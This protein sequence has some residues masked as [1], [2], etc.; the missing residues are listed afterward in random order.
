MTTKLSFEVRPGW[1]AD[2][3]IP[4]TR[5]LIKSAMKALGTVPR[6]KCPTCRCHLLEGD[7]CSC[8]KQ[9]DDS[10]A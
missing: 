6:V 3:T 10:C 9:G 5:A 7:E 1:S 4:E 8:C 2:F